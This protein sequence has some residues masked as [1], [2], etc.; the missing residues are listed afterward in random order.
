MQRLSVGLEPPV[1]IDG[2]CGKPASPKHNDD[3]R[4][5]DTERAPN[6]APV[7]HVDRGWGCRTGR[8]RH[9]CRLCCRGSDRWQDLGLAHSC[10]RCRGLNPYSRSRPLDAAGGCSLSAWSRILRHPAI[11]VCPVA[12]CL[13][14]N[15]VPH[16]TLSMLTRLQPQE[17]PPTA[18]HRTGCAHQCVTIVRTAVRFAASRKFDRGQ[19]LDRAALDTLSELA[20]DRERPQ[21]TQPGSAALLFRRTDAPADEGSPRLPKVVRHNR[22]KR[23]IAFTI[24][25]LLKRECACDR[26]RPRK[27]PARKGR[28]AR[29]P[30]GH[31]A[32]SAGPLLFS[33]GGLC[34]LAATLGS[35][36]LGP[37]CTLVR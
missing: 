18:Q 8:T 30:G 35:Q 32:V 5:T 13:R 28:T 34:R 3:D 19:A 17:S 2:A 6:P 15:P 20:T 33:L 23:R 12:P 24:C 10:G 37:R 16:R 9:P 26:G 22:H 7:D 11:P 36:P 25:P 31:G 4:K 27:S 29:G 14:T 21:S 1:A